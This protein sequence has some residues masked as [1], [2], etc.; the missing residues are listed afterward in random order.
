MLE[1]DVS[2]I[3]DKVDIAIDRREVLRYLGYRKKE[4]KGVVKEVLAEE[5]AEGY[6][7]IKP[8]ALYSRET[9]KEQQSGIIALNSGVSLSTGSFSQDWQG[10]EYLGVVICTIGAA[11]EDRVDELFAQ[12]DP[13]SALVLDSVGSAAVE[14]VA[15]EINYLICCREKGAGNKVGPRASP[16]YGKW[17]VTDQQLLFSLLPAHKVKVQLNQQC[18]MTP[19]KSCSFCL[20]I[21]GELDYK[22]NPCRRC[23]KENCRYRWSP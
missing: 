5:I 14:A 18:M 9:V 1:N 10:A 20:G 3:P 19:R 12:Q 23:G 13:L 17:S 2:L 11:L 21:G 15:D 22:F 6:R 16:G 8:G 4:A 7:L